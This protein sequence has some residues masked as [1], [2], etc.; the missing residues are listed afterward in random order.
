MWQE[1]EMT[2]DLKELFSFLAPDQILEDEADL[3]AYGKDTAKDFEG[4]AAIVLLPKS[5]E[6]VQQIVAIC[7]REKFSLVPS[8]GRT[9]LCGGAVAA[10]GEVVLSLQKMNKIGEILV[11]D[12]MVTCQAGVVTQNL[13]DAL[14]P[15]GLTFPISLA[16]QGSSQIGGN[17][18]TNA[19]GIHFI[20][21]GGTRSWV[22]GL[23]VVTGTGEI[24]RTGRPLYKDN[25]GYDLKGLFVGSEGTLGIITEVTLALAELSK[26]PLRLV[27]ASHSIENLLSLLGKL[28]AEFPVVNAFEFMAEP[29]ID[30]VLSHR[31]LQDP[32]SERHPY[33]AYVDIEQCSAEDPEKLEQIL[34]PLIEEELLNDVVIAQSGQQG[35]NLLALR[36]WISETVTSHYSVHKNDISVPVSRIAAFERD[37]RELFQAEFPQYH[38][39]LFGH[40]ADANIH[41]NCLKP[42]HESDELFFQ[43]S[44]EADLKVS[45][46]ISQHNGSISAEHGI[47]LLKKDLIHFTRSEGELNFMRQ[48][49]A[50][51]DPDGILNPG[52][53]F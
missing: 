52:K 31:N 30:I 38:L 36:E 23:T 32:F 28:R 53:I 33:Y 2:N 35:E 17:V 47:G 26:N 18:S 19:G 12:R 7:R 22:L 6:E 16:A 50:A 13:K 1:P 27:C 24:L 37:L 43:R 40:L 9:G 29:A 46:L 15:Y 25:T 14:A 44:H 45:A 42:E 11:D 48:I 3:T 5:T 21:H 8:G 4:K 51:F 49:K 10:N 20:R 34:M 39:V 41:L